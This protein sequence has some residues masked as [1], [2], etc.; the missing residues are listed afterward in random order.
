MGDAL[1]LGDGQVMTKTFYS[2]K[3]MV[4]LWWPCWW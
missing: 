1:G 4:R 3:I 2:V